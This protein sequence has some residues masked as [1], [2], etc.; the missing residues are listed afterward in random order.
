MIWP[1]ARLRKWKMVRNL[2]EFPRLRCLAVVTLASFLIYVPEAPMS[3]SRVGL[4]TLVL[5]AA[6]A[7]VAP[8]VV[9]A[10]E[11]RA[12]PNEAQ[13]KIAA[14]ARVPQPI[15]CGGGCSSYYYAPPG[16]ASPPTPAPVAPS[17]AVPV[18]PA[19]PVAPTYYT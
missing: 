7:L 8:A 12:P 4:I 19:V 10:S 14:V 13:T 17:P 18:V 5:V 6:V 11:S 15:G 2:P 16:P 3:Q 9:K 1:A